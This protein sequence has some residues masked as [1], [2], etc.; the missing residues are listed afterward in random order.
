MDNSL[1]DHKIK[2]RDDDMRTQLLIMSFLLVYTIPSLVLGGPVVYNVDGQDY[3]GY[4]QESKKGAPLLIMVHDWDGLTEYEV[5]RAEMLAEQGYNVF[6]LDMFGKGVRPTET[7]DKKALTGALYK[8]REKMR[9]LLQAGYAEAVKQSG[10]SGKVVYF[11]YCFGGAVVL[12]MAR[13]GNPAAGFVS[14]HGGLTTPEGQS[15]KDTSGKVMI[16]HGT[17][18]AAVSMQDFGNLAVH[19]EEAKIDHE[20]VTYSGAPHAFTVFGSKRYHEEA[21]RQSWRRFLTFL[22]EI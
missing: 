2:K 20:M 18:D 3:E 12:E 1:T 17:A 4:F 8:D 21:D 10:T 9:K 22:Q 7:E 19:L 15:Y 6:G 13:S 14:F 5:Q 11:G 16:F